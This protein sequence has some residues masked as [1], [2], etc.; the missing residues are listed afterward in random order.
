M[1]DERFIRAADV[2][3]TALGTRRVVGSVAPV[4]A[5]IGAA[6]TVAFLFIPNAKWS[7]LF[8]LTVAVVCATSA[9]LNLRGRT[10]AAGW[11][12]LPVLVI[13]PAIEPVATG[14]LSTNAMYVGLG[15]AFTLLVV[16]WPRRWWVLL[17]A[18]ASLASMLI[19][20][21][22]DRSPEVAWMAAAVNGAVMLAISLALAV[23]LLRTYWD[24]IARA[25]AARRLAERRA[26]DL[27]DINAGLTDAVA[28]R[29][30]ELTAAI[31]QRRRVAEQLAQTA[32]ADPLTGLR[33]RR[34]LAD[35]WPLLVHGDAA[36]AIVDVDSFKLIND[37]LSYQVGDDALREIATVL[38]REVRP[39]DAVVRYG[40]EEFAVLM[41]GTR[42]QQA[43]AVAETLRSAI[44]AHDWRRIHPDLQVTV[45]VGLSVRSGTNGPEGG[46][47]SAAERAAAMLREADAALYRAKAAGGNRVARCSG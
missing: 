6:A 41:P 26:A 8:S 40:G 9:W 27:T 31:A 14:N 43:T 29:Q 2:A 1:S 19:F 3:V 11:L 38:A 47:E 37:N 22:P 30:S 42:Q 36:V 10:S 4:L 13:G 12:L 20:T 18:A 7:A 25:A 17:A 23:I 33:N 39:H 45:S 28:A 16:G 15:A 34:F 46:D 21:T 44:A 32:L 35:E 5:V 24:L